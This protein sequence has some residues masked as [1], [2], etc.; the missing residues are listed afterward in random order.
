MFSAPKLWLSFSLAQ[1]KD[2]KATIFEQSEML[3][4]WPQNTSRASK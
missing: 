3:A 4:A 1:A 2:A